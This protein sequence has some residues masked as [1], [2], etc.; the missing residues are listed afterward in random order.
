MNN[1]KRRISL[2]IKLSSV[3]T[4]FILVTL[5]VFSF[6]SIR[7]VE[8]SGRD[9]AILMG[10]G[11]LASD[12]L[13]YEDM[14]SSNL[15]QLRLV[16]GDLVGDEGK[17]IKYKYELIDALS[18]QLGIVATLFIKENNDYRRISTSII[19]STGKR[20]VDTFLGSG[21]AAYPSIQSGK[22]YNGIAV[23]LGKDYLSLYEPVFAPNSKDVIGIFFIGIEMTHIY[24]AIS[25]NI[26]REIVLIIIIAA[27]SIIALIL[28]NTLS[29]RIILLRP[30]RL[31]T[32]MLVELAVGEGDLTKRIEIANR[33]EIGELAFYFN[34]TLENIKNLVS[35]IKYKVNA[36]TNTGY[37]LSVNMEK[38]SNAV[39][40]I[41]KNFEGIKKLE[42]E[43][44]QGS[45]DVNKSLEDIR[46]SIDLQDKLIDDQTESVN[47]SSSA[48]EEMTANV[49][50]VTMTL[51]ENSKNVDTLTEASE[52]GSASLQTVAQ[53]IKEIARDSEGLLE[54]NAVMNSIAS[55]TNLLSMNAAI[56]AAH[57]GEAGRGFAVV[58][59]EIRKLAESSG[60]QSKTTAAMLKKIK[61]SIDNITKSSDEV[62][63]RFGAINTGIKT[64]SQHELNI[65][66][67]ME[68]QEI[69]GK[70][71]LDAIS[72][73]K[74]ITVS[75]QKGSDNMSQS[76]SDLVKEADEFIKISNKALDSMSA[77]VN[78]ALKEIKTAV[79]HVS[80]MSLENNKNFED[81]KKETEKFKISTGNDKKKI[82]AVDDDEIHLTLTSSMLESHYEIATAKSGQEA[83]KL[84]YQ[85]YNPSLIFLDLSMPEVDGWSTFERIKGISNLHGV[86]TAI[87]TVSDDP[88]DMEKAKKMGAADYIKKPCNRDELLERV[89]KML[90][91]V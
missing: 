74:E 71:I 80:E 42:D 57:A 79:G 44:K 28:I 36:L 10:K 50:S 66:N 5:I 41:S 81:L 85:G 33:D 21:S 25:A 12:I 3:S 51:V 58:A 16:N 4:A 64:V 76:G 24:Q 2:L 70:Q 35:I 59:D 19:D 87:F 26:S 27:I 45:V 6:F 48:I 84:L 91:Q 22:A 69:G 75:V 23:I 54:I 38:T 18:S 34:K 90:K 31:V 30:I 82:L 63:S 53:E 1:E 73:L 7:A 65:R 13:H 43:Q 14:I 9:A 55:Q 29:F 86:P 61:A 62:L 88:R 56:E 60:K 11:K 77:I 17:S 47:A 89:A 15:G 52:Y 37:E 20:A 83:L 8:E 49:H 68:E 39:S 40:Q 67:A 32:K 46:T 78:G 72:R